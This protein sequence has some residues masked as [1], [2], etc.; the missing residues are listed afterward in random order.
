MKILKY[1][2]QRSINKALM[3]ALATEVKAKLDDRDVRDVSNFD[4]HT[5][6]ASFGTAPEMPERYV[7]FDDGLSS[8][9]NNSLSM[10][11]GHL[12]PNN[13]MFIINNED[14]LYIVALLEEVKKGLED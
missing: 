12:N 3:K 7:E 13:A 8:R 5:K 11:T 2:A 6:L 10:M 4:M 14:A 9:L 1:F